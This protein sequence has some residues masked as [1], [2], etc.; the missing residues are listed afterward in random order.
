[1]S[2]SDEINNKRQ[3]ARVSGL[4]N[5]EVMID[6]NWQNGKMLNISTQ[7]A[8]L[9]V[10]SQVS[11]GAEVLLKI[12]QLGPF[13]TTVIWQSNN[14]MGVKFFHDNLEMAGVILELASYG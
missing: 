4:M 3:E 12:S 2:E 5:V 9:Q 14:E 13:K 10:D 1:M 8:K 7:G 11:E 6:G